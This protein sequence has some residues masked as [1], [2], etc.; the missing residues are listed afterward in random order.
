VEQRLEELRQSIRGYYSDL[1]GA[2]EPHHN[3]REP[4]QAVAP[5]S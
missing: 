5:N 3:R 2:P 1:A 4:S